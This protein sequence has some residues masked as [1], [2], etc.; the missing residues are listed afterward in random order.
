MTSM[1]CTK[2]NIN[3]CL[4]EKTK[5]ILKSLCDNGFYVE[6]DHNPELLGRHSEN[7]GMTLAYKIVAP[8]ETP[9]QVA[10]THE[11]LHI[12]LFAFG[13]VDSNTIRNVVDKDY[14]YFSYELL[15][16]LNNNL[17]HFKMLP[18]FTSIGFDKKDFLHGNLS[19]Q[20]AQSKE[21]IEILNNDSNKNLRLQK[22]ICEYS[23]LKFFENF[24]DLDTKDCLN[25][26]YQLDN[27]L[28]NILEQS[29]S[30]W[31]K[32][33]SYDNLKFFQ[34]LMTRIKKIDEKIPTDN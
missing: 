29:F 2:M 9:N 32:S 16:K 21:R 17:A 31:N 11:L 1:N 25:K 18:T 34:T 27:D 33:I 5:R 23:I 22:I 7:W 26:L 28:F 14:K 10:F 15:D 30:E 6:L 24:E 8:N 20:L 3:D 13:F 12:Q 19:E 4:T